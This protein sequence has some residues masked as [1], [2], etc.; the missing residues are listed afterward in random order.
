MPSQSSYLGPKE[1]RTAI[2]VIRAWNET[3]ESLPPVPRAVLTN[4]AVPYGRTFRQWDANGDLWI[5]A[6]ADQFA[7]LPRRRH[8]ASDPPLFGIPVV[9]R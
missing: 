2:D 4:H 7:S 8:H 1:G 6:N 9:S 5:W 3:I